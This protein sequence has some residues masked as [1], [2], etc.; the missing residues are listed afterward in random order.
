MEFI[1]FFYFEKV[2]IFIAKTKNN[3]LNGY[4]CYLMLNKLQKINKFKQDNQINK[5][6][7]TLSHC[8]WARTFVLVIQ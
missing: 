1:T 5:E 3:F 7:P 6:E 2:F 8:A 4:K